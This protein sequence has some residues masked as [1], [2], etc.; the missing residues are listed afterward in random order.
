VR[1]VRS[2]AFFPDGERLIVTAD[3][4]PASVWSLTDDR[5]IGSLESSVG[6][7]G[8]FFSADGALIAG[9]PTQGGRGIWRASDLALLCE[10]GS[11]GPFSP[12]GLFMA[13]SAYNGIVLIGLPGNR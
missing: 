10:I 1:G 11:V 3:D 2:A 5:P 7:G 6:A 13:T 12:D 4:Q 9:P 8:L